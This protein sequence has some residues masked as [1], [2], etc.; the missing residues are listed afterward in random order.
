[1]TDPCPSELTLSMHADRELAAAD[2]VATEMHLA[3]CWSCRMRLAGLR[4]ETSIV[5][6][7][8]AHD[9][10][11]LKTPAYRRP[12]S[13]FAMAATAAGGVLLAVL[14]AVVPSVITGLLSGPIQ[15]FNPFDKGTI[16]DIGVEAAIFLAKQGGAI[17]TSIGKTVAMAMFTTFIGWLALARPRRN[18]AHLPLI[19]AA[20]FGLVAMQPTPS[21]ALEI[22]HEKS[23]V[24]IPAGETIDD[25]LIVSGETVEVAGDVT[26][27]LIAVGRR[28]TVRGHV[29]GQVFAFGQ[30]VNVEGE[31]GGNVTSAAETLGISALHVGGNLYGVGSTVNLNPAANIDANAVLGGEHLRL[32]GSVGRDVL[33]AGENVDVSGTIGGALTAYAQALK[34]L[35]PARIAGPVT[36]YVQHADDLTVSP[37]AVIGGK[38]ETKLVEGHLE[39]NRYL[40]GGFYLSQLLRFVAALI[41][42]T[43][44]LTL[45][46]GLR[47]VGVDDA[48][49]ALIAGGVGIVTLVAMPII[50]VIVALTIIGL[51]LGVLGLL[52]W[53]V[54]LYLAKL[55]VAN[56][57]GMRLNADRDEPRHFIV[58]L[59]VGLALVIVAVNLPL[60]GHV[61]SFVLTIVGLGLLVLFGWR[62]YSGR[63][64]SDD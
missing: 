13:R 19:I 7:A 16:A 3:G 35:P 15:W 48:R 57:I 42:G 60:I 51:P 12:V 54:G 63:A 17:M 59:A 53:I 11:P 50:A 30:T 40:T 9:A 44:L 25:T 58:S 33:S 28:V 32:A 22:R 31:V 5:A 56:F 64:W 14:V 18:R 43:V 49:G 38:V 23:E 61:L 20:L 4:S 39:K 21:Q 52:L 6:A 34:V 47:S 10:E 46:P 8:L 2:A 37:G 1:M 55:V 36:A 26:G 41:T 27:D 45:L 62:G 24:F 29:G